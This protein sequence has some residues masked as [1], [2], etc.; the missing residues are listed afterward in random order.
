MEVP[1]PKAC[2]IRRFKYCARKAEGVAH[3]SC[4][5][6]H[7]AFAN[8]PRALPKQSPWTDATTQAGSG[9]RLWGNESD[10]VPGTMVI[11]SFRLYDAVDDAP[12]P[13]PRA[14]QCNRAH[15]SGESCA[16]RAAGSEEC[17]ELP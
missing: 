6:C 14:R 15:D 5:P 16:I 10:Q 3:N 11:R 4:Q 8:P 17:A 2:R 13:L 12:T 7:V 9:R 1:E